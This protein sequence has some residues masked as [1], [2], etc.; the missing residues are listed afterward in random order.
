M[1]WKSRRDAQEI[2]RNKWVSCQKHMVD[3]KLRRCE[4]SLRLLDALLFH[5]CSYNFGLYHLIYT[6]NN[7]RL[8]RRLSNQEKQ[9]YEGARDFYNYVIPIA[10]SMIIIAHTVQSLSVEEGRSIDIFELLTKFSLDFFAVITYLTAKKYYKL[11]NI[12]D[13][14]P[15]LPST[16]SNIE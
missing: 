9:A 1:K 15:V 7:K 14:T 12:I 2:Y 8:E 6:M 11:C 10:I 13:S 16:T 4:S 5:G 3:F